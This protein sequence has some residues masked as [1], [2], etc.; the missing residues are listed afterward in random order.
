MKDANWVYYRLF[1]EKI[2]CFTLFLV[3]RATAAGT[4]Q[5]VAESLEHLRAATNY[6]WVTTT[7]ME[8]APF[9]IPAING[10]SRQIDYTRNHQT[11]SFEPATY[12]RVGAKIQF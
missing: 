5:E 12:V 10:L 8:D 6:A 4:S 2:F 3:L 11:V 9:I 1:L 7:K